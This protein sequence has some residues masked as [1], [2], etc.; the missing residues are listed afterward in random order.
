M[1]HTYIEEQKEK[2]AQDDS[3]QIDSIDFM[4]E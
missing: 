2:I 3:C 1:K 4:W